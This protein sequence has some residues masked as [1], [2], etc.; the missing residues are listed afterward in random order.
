MSKDAPKLG[1]KKAALSKA[2]RA[3]LSKRK[4]QARAHKSEAVPSKKTSPPPKQEA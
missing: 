2:L 1:G 3:N 4:A